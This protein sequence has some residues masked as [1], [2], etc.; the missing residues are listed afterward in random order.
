MKKYL[1]IP[2]EE[3]PPLGRPGISPHTLRHA[4]AIHLLHAG[5]PPITIKD[6]LGHKDIKSTDVYVETNI[7]MRRKALERV[8][9]PSQNQKERQAAGSRYAHMVGVSVR[10]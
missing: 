4:K 9:T 6:I 7:E 8:G 10:S 1:A 3:M 2:E 5:L